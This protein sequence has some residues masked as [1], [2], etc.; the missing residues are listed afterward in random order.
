MVPYFLLLGQGYF[1]AQTTFTCLLFMKQFQPVLASH[2]DVNTRPGFYELFSL[3]LAIVLLYWVGFKLI[4]TIYAHTVSL[5][6]DSDE[7]DSDSEAIAEDD[8][9]PDGEPSSD[10]EE[11]KVFPKQLPDC[12][13]NCRECKKTLEEEMAAS[14]LNAAAAQPTFQLTP[15][16]SVGDDLLH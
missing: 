6:N 9:G 16:P 8:D 2:V 1:K 13:C 14:A 7:E 12:L 15:E 11:D 5:M 10:E 3:I 4:S